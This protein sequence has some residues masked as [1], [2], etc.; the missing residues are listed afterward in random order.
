MMGRWTGKQISEYNS[1]LNA[2]ESHKRA[3]QICREFYE[4][5]QR[6]GISYAELGRRHGVS[7]T[8]AR[9]RCLKWAER[10]EE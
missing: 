3:I 7:K 6:Y 5:Q 4:E 1:G 8:K 9:E 10:K 2:K